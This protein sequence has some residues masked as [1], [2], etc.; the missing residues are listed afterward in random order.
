MPRHR[1][2]AVARGRPAPAQRPGLHRRRRCEGRHLQGRPAELWRVRRKT[3]VRTRP[4]AQA[5]RPQGRQVG[6]AGL[7]GHLGRRSLRRAEGQGRRDPGGPQRLAL[8]PHRRRR[9]HRRRQGPRRRDRPAD[10]LCQSGGRP[11]RAGVRRRLVRP[12]GR[13]RG[14]D[15][16]ADVRGGPGAF[17]LGARSLRLA[18]R[19]GP[20]DGLA[21]R[22]RGT[23]PGHG[24]GPSGLCGQ[25]RLP[26]R[27]AR[28]LRRHRFGPDRGGGGGRP[29]RPAGP[30]RDAALPLHL[31]RQPG[32]RRGLRAGDRGALSD[33]PHRPRGGGLRGHA[34]PAVR[35]SA[36]RHHRREPAVAGPR[37]DAD[38]AVQ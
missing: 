36:R 8:S 2:A 14:R 10:A 21:D 25:V 32:G 19:R 4:R 26:R 6:R 13:R 34:G 23:L 29:G 18:V 9:A 16:A 22:G 1:R 11:G 24:P 28:P 33:H 15:A 31:R 17:A 30:L 35:G 37:R 38:G 3:G 12:A 27:R 7:R 20:G 5:F